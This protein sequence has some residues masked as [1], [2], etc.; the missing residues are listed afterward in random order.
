MLGVTQKLRR[1]VRTTQ[2]DREREIELR[3]RRGE[4]RMADTKQLAKHVTAD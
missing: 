4:Q 2:M 3:E 1:Q